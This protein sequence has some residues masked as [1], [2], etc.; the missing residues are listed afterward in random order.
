MSYKEGKWFTSPWN[1]I[2]DIKSTLDFSKDIQL[3]DVTLRDGEQQIGVAFSKDDKIRIAEKLAEA[4]IHR[5]EAGLPATSKEDEQAIKEIVKRNLGPKIFSFSRCIKD[6]IKRAVDCGVDGIV[7][8]MPTSEHVIKEAYKWPLE[9]AIDKAIEATLYAKENGLYTVFFPAD[10]TRADI[11]WFLYVAKRIAKD[12]HMD[13]LTIADSFG[14]CSPSTVPYLVRKV[15]Q[16]IDKPIELHFHDDFGLSTAN[17]VLG[18]AAGASVAHTTVCGLGERA[19]NT[20]Y[21]NVVLSLLTMY[22]IDLHIKTEKIY[23]LSKFV[24]DI[25][26]VKIRSNQGIVGDDLF[27]I[28]SGTIVN[29]YRR[30]VR[31]NPLILN[32]YHWDL[33]GQ[34]PFD[35]VLGKHSGLPSIEVWL[36]K[37]NK[38]I[39]EEKLRSIL[40][41][42]KEQAAKQKRLLT[43]KEFEKIIDEEQA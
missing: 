31:E 7:V 27:K 37:L 1:D 35:V 18:L 23:E 40:F 36:E 16:C 30:C 41:K 24:R 29:W 2:E 42:V 32:A 43:I 34:S 39:P 25:A 3:H 9:K 19:G 33:V 38:T 12:G 10:G 6:D 14:G 22:N 13:A 20:S 17:T 5:I 15:K 11:N 4:G 8:E 26:G 28:E 21:E